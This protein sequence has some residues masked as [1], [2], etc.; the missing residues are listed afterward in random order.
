MVKMAFFSGQFRLQRAP[1]SVCQ[2]THHSGHHHHPAHITVVGNAMTC[3]LLLQYPPAG[4]SLLFATSTPGAASPVGKGNTQRLVVSRP[5]LR[6]RHSQGSS[7]AT[8]C[9]SGPAVRRR[10]SFQARPGTSGGAGCWSAGNRSSCT[11][12]VTLP[13]IN[14]RRSHRSGRHS[15]R[16]PVTWSGRRE[17]AVVVRSAVGFLQMVRRIRHVRP[18]AVV[19]ASSA[20]LRRCN[21]APR[22]FRGPPRIR[23]KLRKVQCR[24]SWPLVSRWWQLICSSPPKLRAVL[25]C[26][27]PART[28]QYHPSP[29]ITLPRQPR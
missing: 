10:L 18:A 3:K 19:D 20:F 21:A 8:I 15:V 25:R 16:I 28:D 9:F 27:G 1:P 23:S 17:G 7:A 5:R 24:S 13:E 12:T 22:L 2:S 4:A 14:C 11:R 6:Q 26:A 29:Q